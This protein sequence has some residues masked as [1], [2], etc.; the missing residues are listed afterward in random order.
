M[1][2]GIRLEFVILFGLWLFATV[3]NLNKAYHID[4]TVHLETAQWILHNPLHP[5]S[6]KINW[7]QNADSIHLLSQPHLYFYMLA[8][9]GFLFGFSEVAMHIFQSLF[10]FTCILF[11]YLISKLIV[12]KHALFLTVLLTSSPAFIVGQN[13]MVDVPLL[14][15]WLAFYYL[16]IKPRV[17]SETQRLLLVGFMAGCACLVK[18]SSLPLVLV[19]LVYIILKR[20]FNLIWTISIPIGMLIFWSYFNYLDYGSIHILERPSQPF[21]LKNLLGMGLAWLIGLGSI[22]AYSPLFFGNLWRTRKK[23]HRLVQIALILIILSSVLIFLGVYIGKLDDSITFKYLLS[24]FLGN[25]IA[26]SL[27]LL[28]ELKKNLGG[29]LVEANHSI[30][31][32]YLWLF[33]GAL[34]IIFFS[35]FM[36]TRHILLVIVPITLLLAHFIEIHLSFFWSATAF[37]LSIFLTLSLGISDL[38]WANYYKEKA[39]LI[40]SELPSKA[41]I[42]FTGHWGWQWYAKQNGMQQLETLNPQIQP[43][44]YLVYPN[45][46]HQQRLDKIPSNLHL[47][48]LKEYTESP[49]TLTFFKTDRARFYSSSFKNLPWVI[50]WYPF[51][52][53]IVYQVQTLEGRQQ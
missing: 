39:A 14:S 43:G 6:G 30:L 17:K 29:F 37:F 24:L 47:K 13:L 18:Y 42:Y 11:I 50:N 9:Y 36:A 23:L 1:K 31:I 40:K 41:N 28:Y 15:F 49:S 10:T 46:I 21:S 8:A 26:V 25:G 48:V 4:D 45:G 3:I 53:I 19:M 34:F 38:I 35:P 12:S 51:D 20:K 5:M 7:D 52:K 2:I 44:D 32:L 16:L 27:L 22:L 33:S